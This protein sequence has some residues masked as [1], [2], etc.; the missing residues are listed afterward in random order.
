[1]NE[2]EYRY[3]ASQLQPGRLRAYARRVAREV[4][5]KGRPALQALPVDEPVEVE[6]KIFG[7]VYSRTTTNNRSYLHCWPLGEVV[8]DDRLSVTREPN[9]QFSQNRTTRGLAV[10]LRHDGEI[11]RADLC[12]TSD[13]DNPYQN[14]R[15]ANDSDLC[16]LDRKQVGYTKEVRPNASIG[17]THRE[18]LKN[19]LVLAV[20]QKGLGLSLALNRLRQQAG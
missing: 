17:E 15:I 6:R 5:A 20:D 3:Q 11:L 18:H 14:L 12:R 16:C 19:R 7:F 9:G 10:F 4:T 8:D 13:T 1:M 2:R